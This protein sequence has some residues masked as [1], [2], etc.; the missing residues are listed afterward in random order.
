[1]ARIPLVEVN[2]MTAE[3]R[4]QYD[5]FPSNLTRTLLLMDSRLAHA[6]PETA[7]ALRASELD[8]ALR[9]AAILR[10]AALSNSAYERMQHLDQ[11]RKEGWSDEQIAAIESGDHAGLPDIASAVLDFVDASRVAAATERELSGQAMAVMLALASVS[12]RWVT[13]VRGLRSATD[14]GSNATACPR[15]MTVKRP[16]T[17]SWGTLAAAPTIERHS[18]RCPAPHTRLPLSVKSSRELGPALAAKPGGP[19]GACGLVVDAIRRLI[20]SLGQ[21]ARAS[22]GKWVRTW[23]PI[24]GRLMD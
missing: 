21:T 16:R 2:D 20:P 22:A 6:L 10:V 7:N 24:T 11:A 17:I 1:M 14:A 5:R 23:I 12:G 9:E 19:S 8:A 3:Q 15:A 18:W 13:P 4:E